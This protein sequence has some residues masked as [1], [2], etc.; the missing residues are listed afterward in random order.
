MN[1]AL[2]VPNSGDPAALID[3]AAEVEAVG[4]DGF[5]LWDHVQVYAGSGF[6]VH[7]PWMLLAGA[8]RTTERLRL[9]TMVTPPSRRRPWALAKQVVTLDHLSGGRAVLGIGLG[10][11]DHDEFGAFGDPADIRERAAITDEALGIIEGVLRGEAVAHAG[12]HFEVHAH[13]HPGSVQVPRPPIW[14]ASTP[15]HRRSLARAARWD[16]VYVN[17]DLSTL[18]PLRPEEVGAYVGD[19]AGRPGFEVVNGRHPDHGSDEYAAAGVTWLLDGPW[20]GPD[21]L[22]DAREALRRG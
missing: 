15:P 9:G 18:A 12:T 16:G 7:D 1:R 10:F 22:V 14:I 4:W 13:L 8:A 6:E 3:L 2:V 17:L 20:P 5:F 11:P 19:L 21:L